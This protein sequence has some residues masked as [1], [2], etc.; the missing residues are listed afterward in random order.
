MVLKFIKKYWAVAFMIATGFAMAYHY[1]RVA[2]LGWFLAAVSSVAFI[3]SNDNLMDVLELAEDQNKTMY[4]VIEILR[5]E[6]HGS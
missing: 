1:D 6:N 5:K 2:R 4:Q 3:Q